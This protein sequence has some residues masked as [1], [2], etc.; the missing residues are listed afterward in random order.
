[1]TIRWRIEIAAAFLA[2]LIDHAKEA[3]RDEAKL[4]KSKGSLA[5]LISFEEDRLVSLMLDVTLKRALE[6][7]KQGHA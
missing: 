1:L 4:A 5:D 6:I 3:A 7:D 2:A